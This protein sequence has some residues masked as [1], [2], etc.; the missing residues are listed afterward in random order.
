MI[1]KRMFRLIIYG[2]ILVSV[3]NVVSNYFVELPFSMD[4][5]WLILLI[6]NLVILKSKNLDAISFYYFLFVIIIVLPYGWY[7][8]GAGVSSSIG[9]IF[10]LM[11][12]ITY[13][14]E[15]VKRNSLIIVLI[16]LFLILFYL[17]YNFPEIAKVYDEN[18]LLLDRIIHVPIN[19][20]V[21]YYFIRQFEKLYR[22]EK[23]IVESISLKLKIANEELNKYVNFDNLTNISNRRLFDI[24]FGKIFAVQEEIEVFIVLMDI[25]NLKK[26]NDEYGHLKGDEFII[27]F[28]SIASNEFSR[29]HI[30]SRWGGDEFGLI[31]HGEYIE[32]LDKINKVKKE[33]S[34]SIL[35]IKIDKTISVGITK[36]IYGMPKNELLMKADEA[37]YKT[38]IQGKNGITFIS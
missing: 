4:I 30:F 21:S 14:F 8:S 29:P 1:E 23:R 13:L 24:E 5:K 20:I 10:L 6:I 28:S 18:A 34:N 16:S 12:F 31:F 2:I 37:L 25:D 19:L 7:N 11:I 27:E 22:D 32:L 9:Y 35:D 3:V 36:F 33:F 15:G 17:E 26:V 38:K